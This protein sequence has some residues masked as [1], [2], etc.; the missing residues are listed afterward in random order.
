MAIALRYAAR[1]DIGLGRYKNNQDSAY[2][3]P[4]LLVVCDG[5][6]GH[7]GGDVASSTAIGELAALDDEAHGSDDALQHLEDA[8]HAANRRM[9]ERVAEDPDL[10]G[11]GTTVTALLRSESRLAL[12]HIGDSR[13]YLL[14][15]DVLTQV[16]KDHTFVQWLVDEGRITPDEAEVH[17]QRSVVMRVLGDVD[18]GDELDTSVREA[19][20]GDRWLLCSDGL[21]G[22]VS[23]ETLADTLREVPD[24]AA[25]AERLVEL[26]L[27]GGGQDNITCIVADVVDAAS[28]P[29]SS[30][31]VVGAAAHDRRRPSAAAD[32]PAA[33]AA[34]LSR[35]AEDGDDDEEDDE[36]PPVARRRG[37][38]RGLGALVV[39]GVLAAGSW[40]G[41]QWLQQQY[42]VGVEADDVA[43][44]QGLSQDVGPVSLHRLHEQQ[45]LPVDSLPAVWR[46]SVDEG[47]PADDLD[48]ARR[49]VTNL[50]QRSDVC[51][52]VEPDDQPTTGPV[53]PVTG[54]PSPAPTAAPTVP[55]PLPTGDPTPLPT[56]PAAG[57]EPTTA[58]TSTPVPTNRY[59]DPVPEDCTE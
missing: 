17:P 25:C 33:R 44:F 15:D 12:A 54:Q 8:I 51:A 21:S 35:G 14:S 7:A 13:A 43:I 28:A 29:S 18:A 6:G 38:L 11:M 40:A 42:F 5:M 46:E 53:D 34:A 37:W 3:G 52:A 31:Q 41:W 24:A 50:L 39:L 36:D 22:F 59:G 2:A 26:A 57:G 4:H 47:I 56:A 32:S 45:D 58:P 48:D 23:D 20:V 1:S 16:T 10:A 55:T 30:P 49:I 9:K 27:R 19:R